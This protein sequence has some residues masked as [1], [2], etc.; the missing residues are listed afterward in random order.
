MPGVAAA[1]ALKVSV[2]ELPAI[3]DAGLK[4]AVTPP[5]SAPVLNATVPEP[6]MLTVEVTEPPRLTETLEGLAWSEKFELACVTVSVS[7][8]EWVALPSV[9]VTVTV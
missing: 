9:A 2:A 4:L 8:T 1:D 7:W 6:L 5:G 3:T